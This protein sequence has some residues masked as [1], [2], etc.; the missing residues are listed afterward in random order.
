MPNK[1]FNKQVPGFGFNAGGRAMKMGGG[2]MISGTR[3]KDEASG[4]YSPDMGMK[5]GKMMKKGGPVKKKKMKQGYKD[6]KDESIAMRIRKKRT[7]KQL[8]ASRDE[9]YGKFGSKM[10]KKGKINR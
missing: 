1:R 6:R 10:K 2:K 3:R 7:A 8:K 5:G 9:S 4:F